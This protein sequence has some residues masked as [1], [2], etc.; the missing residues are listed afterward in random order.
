MTV[1]ICLWSHHSFWKQIVKPEKDMMH[2]HCEEIYVKYV[3]WLVAP[4]PLYWRFFQCARRWRDTGHREHA[5]NMLKYGLW[6]W[7]IHLHLLYNYKCMFSKKYSELR[8]YR[9]LTLCFWIP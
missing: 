7:C 2:Q 4:L 3:A 6:L 1:I 9:M 8:F 5:F